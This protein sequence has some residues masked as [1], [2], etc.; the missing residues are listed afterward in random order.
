MTEGDIVAHIYAYRLGNK[1]INDACSNLT[2]KYKIF[3]Y[4][5]SCAKKIYTKIKLIDSN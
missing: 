2:A 1:P 5:A 4:I 3:S